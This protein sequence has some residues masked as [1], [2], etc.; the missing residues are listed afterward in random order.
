MIFNGLWNIRPY[1]ISAVRRNH[2]NH[3]IFTGLESCIMVRGSMKCKKRLRREMKKW[4]DEF[5]EKGERIRG[6]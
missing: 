3:R 6:G 2:G 1:C 5:H 4:T